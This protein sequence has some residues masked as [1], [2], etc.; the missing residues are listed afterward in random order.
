M[1]VTF[2]AAH[3]VDGSTRNMFR[4]NCDQ[5]Y[6]DAVEEAERAGLMSLDVGWPTTD[7]FTCANCQMSI[8]LANG[9]ARDLLAWLGIDMLD[10]YGSM[11][12]REVAALCRRRLWNETRNHD[13]EVPGFD[14]QKP[15]QARVIYQGRRPGY[16][17][18]QTERLLKI[19]EAAGDNLVSWC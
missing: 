9:N 1:S 11:P 4:C 18:E 10:G 15:D 3:E 2:Y 13:P 16:L 19:A 8:N 12:A 17:R 7:Q 14:S 6:C 5:R